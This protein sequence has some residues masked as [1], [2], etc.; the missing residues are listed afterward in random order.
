QARIGRFPIWR[1]E[2]TSGCRDSELLL[3]HS[4]PELG[5]RAYVQLLVDTGK[6]GL[7][8]F[9]ADQHRSSDLPVGLSIRRQLCDPVFR[10]CQLAALSPPD[11]KTSKFALRLLSPKSRARDGES[12]KCSF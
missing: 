6:V 5:T 1:L 2:P 4:T 12:V 8:R 9:R 3:S 10:R 7:D 11:T